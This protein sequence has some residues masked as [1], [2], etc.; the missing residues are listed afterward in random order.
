MTK[1]EA[2]QWAW[3]VLGVCNLRRTVEAELEV[4]EIMPLA[5]AKKIADAAEEIASRFFDLAPDHI[6]EAWCKNVYPAVKP[7]GKK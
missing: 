2:K 6:R 1:R 5:D 7:N 4:A 3:A